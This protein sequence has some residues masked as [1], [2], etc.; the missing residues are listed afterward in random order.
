[1][2][3]EAQAAGPVNKIGAHAG[4]FEDPFDDA[5]AALAAIA[6]REQITQR[7]DLALHAGDLDHVLHAAHAIAHALYM[8]DQVQR[9]CDVHADRAQRQIAGCHEHHV[10]E[11]VEGIA[12]RVRVHGRHRA[13][14]AGVHRLQHVK[15]FSA[16]NLANDDAVGPHAKGIAHQFALRDLAGPF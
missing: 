16:A 10:L 3:L 4:G 9:A 15:C 14:M 2:A 1:M 11:T 12:R 13:V 5:V 7:H 8:Y 6:V